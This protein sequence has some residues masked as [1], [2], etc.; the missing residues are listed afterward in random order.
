MKKSILILVLLLPMTIFAQQ[1]DG[2]FRGGN[3][4]Y[5]NRDVTP[6]SISDG[7]GISNYGVGETV[8]LGSGLLI[9]TAAGAS[10][11][12][13]RRKKGTKLLLAL[14]LLLGMTQCKKKVE[15]ISNPAAIPGVHITLD[16]SGDDGSKVTVTPGYTNPE[17][18]ET[19]ASVAYE[20]GDKIY[21]GYNNAYVGELTYDGTKFSGDVSIAAPVGDQPLHFYLL[22][23]KGFTPTFDG[24]T[25]TVIISDQSEQYPVVSY[26]HS[27]E[28]YTGEG[29]YTSKLRNKCSIMKFNVVT[30]ST[31]PICIMG[32]NN[33]VTV[34]FTNPGG[35]DNGFSYSK[36]QNIGEIKMSAGGGTAKTPAEKWAIV[37]PQDALSAGTNEAY[38][39]ISGSNPYMTGNRP[40]IEAISSNGYYSDATDRTIT[41]NETPKFSVSSSQKVLFAPANLQATTTDKW[42]TWTWSFMEH[43]YSTV[44]EDY[45]NNG[46]NYSKANTA[47]SFKWGATGTS[48]GGYFNPN[49]T[50]MSPKQLPEEQRHDLRLAYGEEWGKCANDA[51]SGDG[52][53]GYNNW[54][55]PSMAEW[56]YV[57]STRTV[58][59]TN[60]EPYGYAIVEG[61]KGIVLLPDNWNGAID[62][63]FVYGSVNGK[64][65]RY[66]SS[67]TP[68]WAA[69]ESSGVVF[70]P[71]AGWRSQ[72]YYVE[73]VGSYGTYWSI[74]YD[75]E[76]DFVTP[77]GSETRTYTYCFSFNYY[78]GDNEELPEDDDLIFETDWAN[79]SS[80]VRL[81]RDID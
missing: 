3:N 65:N 61:V 53:G 45:E 21:V 17:T 13:L 68:S 52:L 62:P 34:D 20:N 74:T 64:T 16:V 29:T 14:A 18:G 15:T 7:G 25:A 19:Y 67:T 51:N 28:V 39:A 35:A 63:S 32:M 72:P 54:R 70:L 77:S 4:D 26:Y 10:Y 49:I 75:K 57:A 22:G 79:Y 55:T 56:T 12:V 1:T 23:G 11:A 66:S 8:P 50:S 37:L 30:G 27:T 60:K 47:S 59:T 38:T 2:F 24:N 9:L 33:M 31:S 73:D 43:Q 36:Y 58:T 46:L 44:E 80:C 6:T 5:Q 40:A 71:A 41:V 76:F 48:I 42:S 69:M 78:G 81:V